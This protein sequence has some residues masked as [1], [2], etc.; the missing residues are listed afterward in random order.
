MDLF[1]ENESPSLDEKITCAVPIIL[2]CTVQIAG[3]ETTKQDAA[4]CS[5][6]P[7]EK[8]FFS[9]AILVLKP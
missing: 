6:K 8:D 4:R 5:V 1:T 7:L 2:K 9:A 3:V